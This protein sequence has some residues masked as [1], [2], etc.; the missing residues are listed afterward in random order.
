MGAIYGSS[1][2]SASVLLTPDVARTPAPVWAT[3]IAHGSAG[4]DKAFDIGEAGFAPGTAMNM[5]M[6]AL[7][8]QEVFFQCSM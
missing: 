4:F 6:C 2:S 5:R 1:L 3:T 7:H 8:N